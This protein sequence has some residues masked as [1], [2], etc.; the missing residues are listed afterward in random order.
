MFFSLV[1]FTPKNFVIGEVYI[2]FLSS[3]KDIEKKEDS[4]FLAEVGFGFQNN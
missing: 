1:E 3:A 4:P 2:F